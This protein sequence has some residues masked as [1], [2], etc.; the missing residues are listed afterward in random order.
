MSEL[1]VFSKPVDDRWKIQS[2]VRVNR[3]VE[4]NN[5]SSNFV[6]ANDASMNSYLT[7]KQAEQEL[8]DRKAREEQLLSGVEELPPDVIKLKET[9]EEKLLK[10]EKC[11]ILTY[12][13]KVSQLNPLAVKD[14]LDM[15]LISPDNMTAREIE[16]LRSVFDDSVV[17]SDSGTIKAKPV[18][19]KS[20]PDDYK[21]TT[22]D[23]LRTKYDF[24]EAM[25][26]ADNYIV[27]DESDLAS[28]FENVDQGNDLSNDDNDS[29]SP[30]E[31]FKDDALNNA[32][33]ALA[34]AASPSIV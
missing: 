6:T 13:Y 24:D 9:Y 2:K 22:K 1:D 34:K 5:I 7:K 12:D 19:R 10:G 28:M 14:A 20:L 15:G 11:K 4:K 3:A 30:D 33:D 16:R 29:L 31:I 17:K 25:K 27:T 32:L 26:A 21:D 23:F 8:Q 18:K